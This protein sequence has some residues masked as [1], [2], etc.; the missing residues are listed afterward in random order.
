MNNSKKTGLIAGI[1][2][3][4]LALYGIVT[5]N[6]FISKEADVDNQWAKVESKLQRRYD[7]IPNLVNSVQGSMKQEKEVFSNITKARENMAGAKGATEVSAASSELEGALSRLLVV[8]ENYPDLKSSE[9]VKTLMTQ[10]EGTENRISVERDRYNESVK[11]YNVALKKFPKS[12]IA[13]MMGLEKEDYFEADEKA[14]EAPTINF[15]E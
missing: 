2:V 12:F 6:G 10:L 5:Y 8:M 1:I 15:D 13:K 14:A 9:N 3:I 7:L 11:R 4:V